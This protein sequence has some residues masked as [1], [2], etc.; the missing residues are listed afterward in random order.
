LLA[1]DLL[2]IGFFIVNQFI[3]HCGFTVVLDR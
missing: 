3:A 2:I 1:L